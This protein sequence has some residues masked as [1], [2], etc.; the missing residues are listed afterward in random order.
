MIGDARLQLAGRRRR[1]RLAIEQPNDAGIRPDLGKD[2]VKVQGPG[3]IDAIGFGQDQLARRHPIGIG[4]DQLIRRKQPLGQQQLFGRFGEFEGAWRKF[5]Q[6]EATVLG[7]ADAED[8][9]ARQIGQR[10]RSGSTQRD[11]RIEAARRRQTIGRKAAGGGKQRRSAARGTA[12]DALDQTPV[13]K[14]PL[15]RNRLP[16]R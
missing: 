3:P 6:G 12:F 10:P 16:V 7:P 15:T 14:G 13:H 11:L 9:A 5:G 8:A 4:Q 1:H 2:V